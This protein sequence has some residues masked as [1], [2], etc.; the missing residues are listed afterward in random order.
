MVHT[1]TV[2]STMRVVHLIKAKQIGGAER[3][4][5][6]LLPALIERGIDIHFLVLTEPDT[7]MDELFTEAEERAFLRRQLWSKA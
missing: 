7:P 6:M 2:Q 4:L 5:L 3:H 1:H